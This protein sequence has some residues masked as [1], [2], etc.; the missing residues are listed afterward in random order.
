MLCSMRVE[1]VVE[2]DVFLGGEV[3]VED[4]EG[5][6]GLGDDLLDGGP[7]GALASPG[8]VG[9]RVSGAP[10]VTRGSGVPEG[11]VPGGLRTGAMW[12]GCGFSGV[13]AG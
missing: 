12:H 6:S 10:G 3:T 2:H 8:F 9:G 13:S 5:G 1:L 4:G 11:A 7:V